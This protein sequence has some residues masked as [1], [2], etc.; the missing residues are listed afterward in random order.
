MNLVSINNYTNTYNFVEADIFYDNKK[1][2]LKK[3]HYVQF[4]Y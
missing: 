4:L 3:L 1:L 2:K